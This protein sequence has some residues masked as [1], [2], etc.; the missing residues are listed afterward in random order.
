MKIKS[1]F[2]VV[3]DFVSPLVTEQMID[4][5]DMY[6]PDTSSE[7]KPIMSSCFHE[8]N[9]EIIFTALQD[10]KPAIEEH[11]GVKYRGTERA[12]FEW[13]PQ[14]STGHEVRCEN[15]AYLRKS[16]VRTQ[17]R[18][19]TCVLFLCDYQDRVPFDSE[20]EVYG[21]K[22]EFPQHRFGFNPQR[23]TMIVF[24]SDPHFLNAISDIIYGDL[25]VA[26]FHIATEDMFVYQPKEFP[27]DYTT[28]LE[29]FA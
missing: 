24:P 21:G 25:F 9:E 2:Y 10:I 3:Q 29:Q 20:Y 4:N 13:Y 22:L 12:R 11:F 6:E 27:G 28:W 17:V 23:G 8:A 26:R 1:P 15:S 18:D 19:L 7:D 5:L 16:W 14:D